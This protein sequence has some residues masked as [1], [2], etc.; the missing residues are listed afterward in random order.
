ME[1]RRPVAWPNL[2]PQSWHAFRTNWRGG[3]LAA[4][5]R[6][7]LEAS[8]PRM[9]EAT[10]RSTLDAKQSFKAK[11]EAHPP[12]AQAGAVR[13]LPRRPGLWPSQSPRWKAVCS[14]TRPQVR[15]RQGRDMG[16][17]AAQEGKK[18][19]GG[20]CRELPLG[21]SGR[22]WSLIPT[23]RPT[24]KTTRT[25]TGII[26]AHR[27]ARRVR[28]WPAVGQVAILCVQYSP[29]GR[30]LNGHYSNNHPG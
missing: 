18:G 3:G 16:V 6:R 20:A 7:R 9:S 22:A 25:N 29:R 4:R 13:L 19:G 15:Q 10:P 24:T 1:G 8:T 21:L 28:L 14:T 11:L 2:R 12:H 30:P 27:A 5:R 23:A 26:G 17:M